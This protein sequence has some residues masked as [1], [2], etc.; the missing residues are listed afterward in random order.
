MK[1][2]NS[3]LKAQ[4]AIANLKGAIYERLKSAGEVGLTN[5]ELGRSLGIYSGH[6]GHEGHIS[7]TL[8]SIMEE[9]GVIKQLE[10]KKWV[11]NG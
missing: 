4:I 6:V 1:F 3:Y 9:E 10:N 5:A 11:L 8:L 2:E 7:R